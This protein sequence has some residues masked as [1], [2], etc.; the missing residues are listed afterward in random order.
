MQAITFCSIVVG[1]YFS[2]SLARDILR[3]KRS[4]HS[5]V[6][7]LN[8]PTTAF[9]ETSYEISS[10]IIVRKIN[11]GNLYLYFYENGT[12]RPVLAI[13]SP[14]LKEKLGVYRYSFSVVNVPG[15]VSRESFADQQKELVLQF[16]KEKI[17][18]P[19]S[20]PNSAFSETSY[21]ISSAI[22]VRKINEGNLYLYYY[23]NGTCRPVLAIRSP[24]LKK[25]LGVYR[26]SF[27]VVNVPDDVS[28]EY[29]ADQQREIVVQFVK[30]KLST[31]KVSKDVS[32]SN[33]EVIVPEQIPALEL[34][35]SSTKNYEEIV[36]EQIPSL[37]LNHSSTKKTFNGLI[38][39]SASYESFPYGN[40]SD[41]EKIRFCARFK[42]GEKEF[43][44]WGSDMRRA[45]NVSRAEVGSVCN[46]I[47]FGKSQVSDE[48]GNKF[49]K[50]L[51]EVD[52]V[53]Q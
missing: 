17:F 1:S 14:W 43:A 23:E 2:V 25:K 48:H 16:V 41:I 9:S 11:E 35:R 19:L 49:Q 29:F 15:D 34:S 21:D 31:S 44:F 33:F 32:T 40:S 7:P 8:V 4:D 47:D 26:F 38:L 3:S 53:K 13:S 37:E 20:V 39:K 30:E 10:D 18:V 51:Y 50:R 24:K 12:C 6:V 5:E 36:P 22:L 27:S 45:I 28:R 42:R 46:V 52:L